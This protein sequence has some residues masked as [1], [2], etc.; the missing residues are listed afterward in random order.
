V[1]DRWLDDFHRHS[2]LEHLADQTDSPIDLVS[3]QPALHEL[4]LACPKRQWAEL[5]RFQ[6]GELGQQDVGGQFDD[7]GLTRGNTI[8]RVVA[9]GVGEI[10][11]CQFGDRDVGLKQG[12]PRDLD[13]SSLREYLT[14]DL[15]VLRLA[16]WGVV[17]T[18]VDISAIDMHNGLA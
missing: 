16:L 14:D 3:A 2:P 17:D 11:G 10:L 6:M 18:K 12:T 4:V 13:L 15:V 9:F 1:Q 5:A 7:R 8:F